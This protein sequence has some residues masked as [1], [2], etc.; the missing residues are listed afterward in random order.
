VDPELTLHPGLRLLR[1]AR[2]ALARQH[3]F[4]IV[5]TLMAGVI[6]LV[7]ATGI[8]GVLTSSIAAN[9]VARERTVAQQ[10]ANDQI[11]QIR[12]KSY[13]NVGVISGNPPG[14]VPATAA[15][16]NGLA[17]TATV[18]ITYVDD[19]TPTSYATAANYKKVTVTVTRDRDAKQLARFS[20]F[21]APEGRAPYGGINNAIINATV[22][23]LGLGQPYVGATVNLTNGPSPNRTDTTDSAGTVSFAALTPNPTTGAQAYYDLTVTAAAGYETLPADVPPGTATPPSTPSHIQLA[24]AQTSNTSIQIYK[25]ATINL[26]LVDGGGSPYTAGAALRI[27]SSFTGATTTDSVS[28]GASG[29]T[30]T[31][32]GGDKIIPGATYTVEGR[33]TSGLCAMPAA[34]PVPSSGYPGNTT[35]TFTLQFTP[36]PS[37]DIA[38]NVKQLGIDM[39]G[40]A[41]TVTGG[42]NNMSL[43]GTTDASGNATFTVPEGTGYTVTA[44]RAGQSAS[45]AAAVTAGATTNVALVLPNPPTGTLNVNVTQFATGVA[46]ATVELSG[47]PWS[48]GPITGTTNGSGQVTFAS[49]PAGAGYSI[50]ATSGADTASTTA[51]V[52]TG[53]TTVNLALPDPPVGTIVTTVTWLSVAA[54][55]VTVTLTGGP[56]SVN[57]SGTTNA[58]GQVTF[59]NVPSGSGYT[60]TATKGLS[61]SASASVTTGST[62][63][64]ALAMPTGTITVSATWA[65]LFAAD[66]TVTI[67]GGP[68]SGTYTD[69]TA[70]GTGVAPAITVPATTSAYPYTVTVTKNT[71][72]SGG[73]AVSSVPAST[74]VP[75]SAAILPTKVLTLTLR[76]GSSTSYTTI[77]STPVTVSLTAGPNGT[78]GAQPAYQYIGNTDT[79]SRVTLTVPAVTGTT[80]TYT[81]KVYMTACPTSPSTANRS[82]TQTVNARTTTTSAIIYLNSATC[83]VTIP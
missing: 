61:V 37:G 70:A 77:P 47:G 36:C 67:T 52:S 26:V 78:A 11:E 66:A 64:V 59:T 81:V 1:R 20:T 13:D 43:T 8:A 56:Q 19:P 18:T 48:I 80:Y 79:S 34:S 68:M 38:V 44:T 54:P 83:P 62:T 82:R 24:P 3:G 75:V 9:T 60:V 22:V 45:S 65:S 29:K 55:G 69:T 15:C 76:R 32:L 25:P 53:T 63:S 10:C 58:S 6:L 50:T 21:V 31:L 4:T 27:T 40:A 17:A 71:G 33:T 23:D 72:S 30:I 12:R 73:I 7:L 14:T 46:G 41:V 51:T 42:P 2:R 74:D 57:V 35:E 16:G 49:V 28:S 39:A 5:E